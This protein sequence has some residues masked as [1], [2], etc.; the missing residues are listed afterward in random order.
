MAES[1][2]DST[3]TSSAAQS[4]AD[5]TIEALA[6]DELA[7]RDRIAEI[8]SEREWYREIA[9]TALTAYVE[10]KRKRKAAQADYYRLRDEQRWPQGVAEKVTR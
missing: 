10:E 2:H 8:L 5:L 3:S 9:Q 7:L 6:H 1:A 4:V